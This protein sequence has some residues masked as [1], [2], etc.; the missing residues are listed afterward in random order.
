ML[1]ISTNKSTYL[2][3]HDVWN[4]RELKVKIRNFHHPILIA[5]FKREQ[6]DPFLL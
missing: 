1:T 3:F 6:S 2:Y 4:T 5:E